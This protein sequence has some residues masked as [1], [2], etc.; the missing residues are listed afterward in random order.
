MKEYDER[1]LKIAE[2]VFEKGD[3][4]IEQ[5]RKKAAKRRHI[6]YGVSGF[7]AALIVCAGAFHLSSSAKMHDD[8]FKC[9][10]PVSSAEKVTGT[11]TA[12]T[13]DTAY[14]AANSINITTASETSAASAIASTGNTTTETIT[15]FITDPPLMEAEEEL[16]DTQPVTEEPQPASDTTAVTSVQ[17]EVDSGDYPVC[18]T[19][20]S[21]R[22][23]PFPGIDT[24][25][26]YISAVVT[27]IEEVFRS[28]DA[29]ITMGSDVRTVYKKQDRLIPAE[30]LG[31]YIGTIT[32]TILVS[33]S[34]TV[35]EDMQVYGIKD[36]SQEEAVAVRLTDTCEFYLF[37]APAYEGRD[38]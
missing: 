4:I 29:S 30:K 5:R 37:A 38:G 33:G 27:D 12:V 34:K 19:T 28:H 11:V 2:R 23:I 1:T 8:S 7:C 24:I 25:G 16:P 20:A 6:S 22:Y 14:S 31:D 32:V 36:I 3:R 17:P 9:T 13:A 35:D 10:E 21:A 18:T 26:G 15:E